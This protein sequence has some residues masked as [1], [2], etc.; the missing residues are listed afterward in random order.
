MKTK[1][2]INASAAGYRLL[3]ICQARGYSTKELF[4]YDLVTTS[5]LF[6][7]EGLMTKPVKYMF[8]HELEKTLEPVHREASPVSWQEMQTVYIVD[9]MSNFRNLILAGLQTF[10]DM[11]AALARYFSCL[12]LSLIHTLNAQ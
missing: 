11:C 6:D 4:S 1:R 8:I 2:K 10:N 12:I 3:D 9:V 5:Y 7:N